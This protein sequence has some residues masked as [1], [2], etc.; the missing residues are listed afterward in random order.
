MDI[1]ECYKYI[2]LLAQ[3]EQ[4]GF[5]KPTDF[6][7]AMD[8]AQM[9]FINDRFGQPA[10]FTANRPSSRIAFPQSQKVLDDLRELSDITVL[11]T[12]S[13][14]SVNVTSGGS[15]Y[16]VGTN[17]TITNAPTAITGYDSILTTTLGTGELSFTLSSV[18]VG[19]TSSPTIVVSAPANGVT[20]QLNATV[21]VLTGFID[22][23][24]IVNSGSGYTNA[25]LSTLTVTF[26]GGGATTQG[27]ATAA[28]SAVA[29]DSIETINILDAG[30][31]LIGSGS[32]NLSFSPT[33]AGIT[34]AVG[35]C[36][37]SIVSTLPTDYLYTISLSDN[38][39]NVS[40]KWV[41]KD[42]AIDLIDSTMLAPDASRPIAW[43]DDANTTAMLSHPTTDIK[44]QYIRKPNKP[45]WGYTSNAQNQLVY[46]VGSSTQ[47]ELR[48]QTHLEICM[49]ALEILGVNLKDQA[50]QQ[51][52]TSKQTKTE[53]V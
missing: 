15:G 34:D 42:Q 2:Q 22:S 45:F 6:N 24:V 16:T 28:F 36:T 51:F 37:Q 5:I 38:N 52:A 13:I 1:N 12:A 29:A 17:P 32:T 9:E 23:F 53:G 49:R 35:T 31:N 11:N 40:V 10:E 25:E 21:D 19:Y 27:A 7:L 33:G 3:K 20:A 4:K 46:D 50:I 39:S 44:L 41:T 48:E 26:T 8:A 14:T 30:F 43:L 47:L 18:G